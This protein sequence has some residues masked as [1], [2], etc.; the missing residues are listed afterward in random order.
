MSFNKKSLAKRSAVFACMLSLCGSVF[1]ATMSVAA[2]AE[3]EAKTSAET[4]AIDS[5][6]YYDNLT[7][8][9]KEYELGKKFYA[10]LDEMRASGDFKDGVISYDIGK[11]VTS[12]QLEAWVEDGDLT[13]PKAFGAARDAFLMDHPELFYIDIYKIMISAGYSGGKYVGY[14]DSGREP[15]IYRDD[16]FKSEAE[17]DKAITAYNAAVKKFAA[18]ARAGVDQAS[19][20]YKD[21]CKLAVAA[22]NEIAQK[23]EY[24]YAVYND[25]VENGENA[26]ST[27]SLA[28]TAYG[29]LVNKKAVCSGYSFGYKAVM[30]E[31]G[32]ETVTVSGY[33]IG[34]DR[35]T[36]ENTDGN[37]P[38]SW[39]YVRLETGEKTEASAAAKTSAAT[40]AQKTY[41]WFA[42]DTTWNSVSVDKNKYSVMYSVEAAEEH[43]PDEIVS[44]S[45]Y[46]LS[47]P[48]LST[49]MYVQAIDPNSPNSEIEV[50]GFKQNTLCTPSGASLDVKS[51]VSYNGKNSGD[52]AKTENLRLVQRLY[53]MDPETSEKK[54]RPWQDMANT[55]AYVEQGHTGLGIKDY[56]DKTFSYISQN[57]QFYQF[58]VV[59]GVE[60]DVDLD[61]GLTTFNGIE[62][63]DGVVEENAI[64]ISDEIE[65][66]VY[67]TY[68]PPP[69]IVAQRSKPIIGTDVT[70]SNSMSEPGDS[71]M[72]A[73]SKAITV[74]LVYDEPLHKLDESKDI[75]VKVTANKDSALQ[76]SGLVK[77]PDGK[78]VHL[79]KSEKGVANTLEFK[80]KPSLMFE[81][82]RVGYKFNFV[83]VGSAKIVEK[84]TEDGGLV[85]TTSDVVPNSAY[86]VFS[87]AIFAC[88]K[89]FGDGRLYVDCCAQPTLVD[90]SDLSATGFLDEDGNP[91]FSESARSQM[92]LVVN[93]VT[94]ETEQAIMNEIDAG[95]NGI[96]KSDIEKSQTYDINLQVCSKIAKVPDGSFVRLSLGFPEGYGPNDEGVTFKIF[97]RK[98][99][100]GGVY[101]IEEIPCV[102]TKFGI[103][104]T[105]NS[106]SPYTVVV[107]PEEKA[108]TKN[109]AASIDGKGGTLSMEEGRVRPVAENG[110]CSYDLT[111]DSGYQLYK[112]TLNGKDITDKVQQNRLT[113]EYADLATN[114]ELEIKYIAAE[115]KTRYEEK[116]I[117]DVAKVVIPV[118]TDIYASAGMSPAPAKPGESS[119]AGLIVG[120]VLGVVIIASAAVVAFLV[121]KKKKEQNAPQKSKQ[122]ASGNAQ[123]ASRS[124]AQQPAQRPT[125]QSVQ[126][127]T[128]QQQARPAA[129]QPRQTQQPSSR[130]T[131]RQPVS[132]QTTRQPVSRSTVQQ[133][134]Q[135]PTAQQPSSRPT[136]KQPVSRS[137]TQQPTQRPTTQQARPN[138]QARPSQSA[139]PTNGTSARTNRPTDD[140]NKR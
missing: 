123:S 81:H 34:K 62:Y 138:T 100:G 97:H 83:N 118:G 122:T 113:V 125:Q 68:T 48:T 133:P 30:D 19:S 116:K 10:A 40:D 6:Y 92:M 44:S 112:V 82:N 84:K 66:P 52:L 99:K 69:Y 131:A 121:V 95:N 80:F 96:K 13:V 135:R 127:P 111:P 129:Q 31:L 53:Y 8:A 93:E 126:R 70:I 49:V 67:G 56:A 21:D 105:V 103:V 41:S 94:P 120:I 39:N 115:A 119:N 114:N 90:N 36:G 134:T 33:S 22:N 2:S 106:F 12:K 72:M 47:Y 20:L 98:H 88:P 87:R 37:V 117:V 71:N 124:T 24:D 128:T 61:Y 5:G 65:N 132:S 7:I 27:A 86:Y 130:P 29:A 57:V 74:K 110:S 14:L 109:I 59:Q 73:D 58:A 16:A 75:E 63:S 42:F 32:V 139:R 28:H 26:E 38:H 4:R 102:V 17:V 137:A 3:S 35:T 108:T 78:Y 60:P 136:M 51:Y 23:V 43:M 11:I 140:K 64:Y 50:G 15:N 89:V 9:G 1:P 46:P 55:A 101:E 104:V 79:T 77:Y 91:T 54:W 18:D 76:Y 107:V 45:K 25:Y 85:R